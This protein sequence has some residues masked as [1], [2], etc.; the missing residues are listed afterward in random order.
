MTN[1]TKE[2]KKEAFKALSC[3]FIEVHESIANDVRN[4]VSDLV[5]AL[6]V[7]LEVADTTDKKMD[8]ILKALKK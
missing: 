4:K 8:I 1:K 3:L 6:E 7:E 2:L 5:T